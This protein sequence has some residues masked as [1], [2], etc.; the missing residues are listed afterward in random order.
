[1][2]APEKLLNAIMNAAKKEQGNCV[3]SDIGFGNVVGINPLEIQLEQKL[4][5]TEKFICVAQHLTDYEIECEITTDEIDGFFTDDVHEGQHQVQVRPGTQ[6][7]KIMLLN[8]LKIGNK[9]LVARFSGGQLY[10]VIDRVE[11]SA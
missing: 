4:K 5:I 11:G 9:V 2:S 3:F 6:K 10:A 8:A 1:M 7:G